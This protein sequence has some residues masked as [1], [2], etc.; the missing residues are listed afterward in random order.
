MTEDGAFS[1]IDSY[2]RLAAHG[3]K[4]LAFR[5]DEY[6]WRDLGTPENIAQAAHD[7]EQQ[8]LASKLAP[9]TPRS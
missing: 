1:I 5:A 3:E 6:Y 8:I 7:L 9:S 2:L 4:I